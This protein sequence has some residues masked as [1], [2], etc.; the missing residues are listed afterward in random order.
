MIAADFDIF[1]HRRKHQTCLDCGKERGNYHRCPKSQ[2]KLDWTWACFVDN[3]GQPV[4]VPG[5][6]K[7]DGPPTV[8][9]ADV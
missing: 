5:V 8:N 6:R 4:W 7:K 9:Y 3:A 1:R 2:A